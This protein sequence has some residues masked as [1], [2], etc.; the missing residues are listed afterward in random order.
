MR[1][2]EEIK[3]KIS[4]TTYSAGVD[5]AGA[6]PLC[7]DLVV[8]AVI[9]D[10]KNP[11]S[12]LNDSKKL[13]EKKRDALYPEIIEKA[14]DYCVVYITPKEIDEMNIFQARMEGFRRAVAG[15]KRVD[16]AILD[17]DKVPSRMLVDTDCLVKGDAKIAAISAASI[18]AKVSRDKQLIEISTQYPEYGFESHK[19]YGTKTHLLALKEHG[20]IDLFHRT[21]FSPVRNSN[22]RV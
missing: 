22:K 20:Y 3:E 6:G 9:L 11:I 2:E 10:P 7:G 13:S 17:G 8:A 4:L 19:G 1:N 15:L 16:Y 14:L 21:S 5:E 12:G 18:L